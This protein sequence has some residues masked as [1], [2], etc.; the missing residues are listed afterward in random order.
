MYLSFRCSKP[1][2]VELMFQRF[3]ETRSF[4]FVQYYLEWDLCSLA[5]VPWLWDE[6]GWLG[7]PA[8]GT[9]R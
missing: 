4:S 3:Y 6:L 8:A 5:W 9:D 7:L 2:L 1:Q